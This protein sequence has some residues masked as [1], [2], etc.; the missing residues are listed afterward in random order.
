MKDYKEALQECRE[1]SR[2]FK[3]TTY[4]VY[5]T[6]TELWIVGLMKP[7]VSSRLKIFSIIKP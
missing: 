5:D 3:M 2:K 4:L 6:V 1:T 7:P